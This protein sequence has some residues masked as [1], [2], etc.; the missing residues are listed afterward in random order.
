MILLEYFSA[1]KK[2]IRMAVIPE[3][4]KNPPTGADLH[5]EF[6]AEI[7]GKVDAIAKEIADIRESVKHAHR[8]DGELQDQADHTLN[9]AR[10]AEQMASAAR[11]ASRY[12][13]ELKIE[14]TNVKP[15]TPEQ[16]VIERVKKQMRKFDK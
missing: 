15:K 8:R 2:A 11:D 4:P 9:M 7:R 14:L 16:K 10:T 1:P 13:R 6:F 5:K 12:P 3:D